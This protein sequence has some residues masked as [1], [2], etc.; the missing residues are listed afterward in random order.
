M[1]ETP[2]GSPASYEAPSVRDRQ[3]RIPVCTPG[4]DPHQSFRKALSYFSKFPHVATHVNE[5][6]GELNR[7][8][9][10]SGIYEPGLTGHCQAHCDSN[11][12]D[13]A[14]SYR[15]ASLRA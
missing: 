8:T 2:D 12:G 9:V 4:F 13:R 15:Q 7:D 5:F 14:S 6:K 1:P 10:S 3:Q 11:N